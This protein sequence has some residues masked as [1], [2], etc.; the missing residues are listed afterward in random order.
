MVDQCPHAAKP[1]GGVQPRGMF[2]RQLVH[3]EIW[4]LDICPATSIGEIDVPGELF[5]IAVGS[6]GT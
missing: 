1:L 3:P 5:D 4:A 2:D 6:L